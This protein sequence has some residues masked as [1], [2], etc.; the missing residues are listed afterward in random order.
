MKRF[1]FLLA[2]VMMI[3][4]TTFAQQVI[5]LPA[6]DFGRK[7]L[8]VA[9]TYIQRKSTREFSD[10]KL[11]EQDLSDLLWAAQGQNRED[12]RLTAPTAMNRQEIRVYVFCEKGVSLYDPHTNTLNVK[13]E[14]DYRN[15]VAQ[16]QE[17][18][19]KAPVSL[20]YVA[21]GDI[22]GSTDEMSMRMMAVDVGIV[23]QNVNIF[24]S[25]AGFVTVPRA[26]MD[27]RAISKLLGLNGNQIPMLNNP[28]GYPD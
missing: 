15:L 23:S 21:D 12:G 9:E 19:A 8:T 11:S 5:K 1:S 16:R 17:F 3:G 6:P 24:C 20:V 18:A 22:F 28:V 2:A 4:Q 14:G 7:T 27:S 10:R 25:A 13:A 26:S